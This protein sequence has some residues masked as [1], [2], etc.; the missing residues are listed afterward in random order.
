MVGP[1]KAIKDK[2]G[3]VGVGPDGDEHL[4]LI[5]KVHVLL[6]GALGSTDA[7]VAQAKPAKGRTRRKKDGA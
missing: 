4:E 7:D 3:G 1:Q 5:E 2:G 6:T